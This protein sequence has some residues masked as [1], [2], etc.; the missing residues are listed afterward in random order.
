V[1]PQGVLGGRT[2]CDRS[3][4][5]DL[6]ESLSHMA[7]CESSVVQ[8]ST[9]ASKTDEETT[10]AVEGPSASVSVGPT[11]HRARKPRKRAQAH[12]SFGLQPW[13]TLAAGWPHRWRRDTLRCLIER[14]HPPRRELL[15]IRQAWEAS[16][17]T[18][19]AVRA[20]GRMGDWNQAKDADGI[21]GSRS[22]QLDF[23]R[24]FAFI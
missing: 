16:A 6:P 12:G 14:S 1:A 15:A 2:T 7:I 4:G 13:E 24:V 8:S 19:P 22:T 10:P 11:P 21:K 5:P 18:G 3:Q 23:I 20:V 17:L 9:T